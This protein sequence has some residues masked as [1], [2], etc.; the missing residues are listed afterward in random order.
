M[1]GSSGIAPKGVDCCHMNGSACCCW[2]YARM[3]GRLG[4]RYTV[5]QVASN[6][7]VSKFSIHIVQMSSVCAAG[8][9]PGCPATLRSVHCRVGRTQQ[10]LVDIDSLVYIHGVAKCQ[11]SNA[12]GAARASWRHVEYLQGVC[13]ALERDSA[14]V[15]QAGGASLQGRRR[16][17]G[18]RAA[19]CCLS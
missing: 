15:A 6:Q 18:A 11:D 10:A 19:A 3:S 2:W 17:S 1:L 8:G 14:S 5:V 9:A 16:S 7:P 4:G 12:Q 13:S